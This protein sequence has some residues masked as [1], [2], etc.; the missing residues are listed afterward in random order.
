MIFGAPLILDAAR[1][2]VAQALA[3]PRDPQPEPY[4]PRKRTLADNL[5]LLADAFRGDHSNE[6]MLAEEEAQARAEW[7]ATQG[8]LLRRAQEFA[9]WQKRYDYETAHPRA[10]A[11]Q[12][13]EF[14][15]LVGASGLPQDQQTQ[16]IQDYIRNRAK[17]GG[18]SLIGAPQGVTFTPI[19]SSAGGAGNASPRPFR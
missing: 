16:I 12:P 19:P 2:G 3:Q 4:K 13:T 10:S 9:D 1:K 11:P 5:G 17:N 7:Q 14:E 18:A 15:R 6:Q 8:A